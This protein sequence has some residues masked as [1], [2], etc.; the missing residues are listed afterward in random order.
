VLIETP[1]K[2][3][4]FRCGRK[5]D[6][7]RFVVMLK[8]L[9][10]AATLSAFI[11]A[12]SFAIT[13]TWNGVTSANWSDAAN[14]SPAGVPQPEDS[15]VF[16]TGGQNRSMMNDLP[17]GTSFG[18]MTCKDFYVVHG[19]LLR[20]TGDVSGLE[21]YADLQLGDSVAFSGHIW[22]AID[23][24]GQTLNLFGGIAGPINGYG[25][26][27]VSTDHFAPI[28][29]NSSGDF[30]GTIRGGPSGGSLALGALCSLPNATVEIESIL[31]EEPGTSTLGD[32]TIL[33]S[34]GGISPQEGLTP[35][36]HT[37]SLSLAPHDAGLSV[38]L[39]ADGCSRIDATGIVALNDARLSVTRFTA[40]GRPAVGQEF[41]I[42]NNEGT[43]P[44]IGTFNALPEGSIVAPVEAN[45]SGLDTYRISYH[46]GDGNDV[47]LTTLTAGIRT[48]TILSQS[49]SA[50]QF[51]EPFTLTATVTA[52]SGTPTG[53]VTFA[54][55]RVALGTAPVEN[56]VATLTVTT[57][58]VGTHQ[59]YG[60]FRGTGLFAD[61]PSIG[62][63]HVVSRVQTNTQIVANNPNTFY[64]QAVLFT[65]T[66]GV[67]APSA[68][69]PA[70]TVT[71]L[72]DGLALGTAA[73]V[74]GAA[75][76]ETS[77]LHA[78][79][80]SI[81]ATYSGDVNFPPST[82]PA[83]NQN[84]A[85]ARTEVDPRLRS[86]IVARE[87][88]M[89]TVFVNGT[90][91]L[92]IVPAGAVTLS[93]RGADLVTQSLVNG[94]AE[95][96]LNAMSPGDHTL[97]VRYGGN[98]DFEPSSAT[99]IQTVVASAISVH[100][101]LVIEG[102]QGVTTVSVVLTLSSAVATP[103]RVSFS[104]LPGSAKEGEDYEKA[105]GVIEFAPG[106]LTGAIELHVFGD[107]LP[108]SDETFSV[109]LS[110]P[111]NAVI[112][113]ASAFIVIVNDDK[114]PPRRRPVRH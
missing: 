101:A 44:V 100:D 112:D 106:E 34:L 5:A 83:I 72:A 29:L 81:M 33:P 82:S 88:P 43:D 80:R 90:P 111:I 23:V 51:G 6:V 87:S 61:S 89:V 20:L 42:I 18:A 84:V 58:T 66:V 63:L 16:P 56:G 71:V 54:E 105:S 94:K 25:T 12:P 96:T 4:V 104:T 41:T 103:V 22:G 26:I 73:V 64:G 78:G 107:T 13:R 46:G 21:S 69:K 99:I 40:G 32:V 49:A 57:L 97:V 109:V 62:V 98:A 79:A 67:Q 68:E 2:G 48:G 70:G 31:L 8:R 110:D 11:A 53:S 93:E 14:W 55:D 65:V 7:P 37:K 85:K 24:N 108:E 60:D 52:E 30:S 75:I 47:V 3:G 27:I 38:T 17:P 74:N 76:F 86:P 114:V 10:F 15:L 95:L 77:V 35:V 19:N 102:N 9:L 113:K 36:L 28:F 59:I 50:T 92:S 91:N 45:A 1:P 39:K